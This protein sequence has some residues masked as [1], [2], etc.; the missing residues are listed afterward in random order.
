MLTP[1][2]ECGKGQADCGLVLPIGSCEA[3]SPG[4]EVQLHPHG[5]CSQLPEPRCPMDAQ[6]MSGVAQHR[7]GGQLAA[8]WQGCKA[9]SSVL[10]PMQLA[11][12]AKNT[13]CTFPLPSSLPSKLLPGCFSGC[14]AYTS[15]AKKA[16]EL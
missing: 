13:P 9:P 12:L 14:S 15:V 10:S 6:E 1:S 3:P 11:E 2:V 16:Q 5:L 8:R 7:V 4:A